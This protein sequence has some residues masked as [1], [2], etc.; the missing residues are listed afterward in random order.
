MSRVDAYN[1]DVLTCLANLSNDEVFTPP[2][3]V[4][5]ILDELPNEIWANPEVTFL[6]PTTKSGVF[7][8]EITKRLLVGL[9]K[10]IPELE[11]RLIHIFGKQI[12][13]IAITELT[14][15][16]SRRSVYCSKNAKGEHSHYL[17]STS[18]DG[19]IRFKPTL[20]SWNKGKCK[21]CGAAQVQNERSNELESHAYEFIHTKTPK[22]IFNMKFDV[23]V[24]NPPYQL[25]DG[26]HG[27]SAKPIYQEF[28]NQAMALNPRYLTMIIP[29]RWIAG[30]KGL[31]EFREQMLND[32]RV[33]KITDYFDSTLCFPGVDISGGVMYFLWA[34]DE[35]GDCE[36]TNV[37]RDGNSTSIRPL[38][39]NG[40][41]GFIRFNDSVGIVKKVLQRTKSW[42]ADEIS[43]RKPFGL[44]TNAKLA[45]KEIRG[46]VFAYAYPRNGY[47]VTS[48]I[49]SNKHLINKYKVMIAYAY[50]ERGQFPYRVI[51]EP[52]IAHPNSVCTETY[53]V[54]NSF[55]TLQEAE[56]LISY[57]KTRFFRFLVLQ[58]KNT[59]HATAKAYAL[60]P[61]LNWTE[62]WNDEKLF[63]LFDITESEK[64]FIISMVRES[65]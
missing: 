51:G 63:K 59:Q 62:H 43:S 14:A 29:S 57:M 31:D 4:N 10:E 58:R 64:S 42:L 60:V 3:L 8:R 6:D 9:E 20:H 55:D 32:S 54:I 37:S 27:T 23:I 12:F 41:S 15:L 26:G 18:E 35:K 61:K 11:Q 39:E 36:I 34:K 56:S 50:G 17:D 48:A 5:K 53:L 40:S 21:F 22:E 24:G 25:K 49:T 19:N 16:M 65:E 7:L 33:R 47:V 28:V 2:S 30:G 1:P 52:F 13:G 46:S 45:E 44:P 38:I